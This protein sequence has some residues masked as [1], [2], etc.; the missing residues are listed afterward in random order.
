[1]AELK[2]TRITD[3]PV[4]T[5]VLTAV[6]ALGI[7]VAFQLAFDGQVSVLESGAFAVVFAAVLVGLS[8]VRQR[9]A[10]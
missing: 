8:L 2:D 7:Y 3:R 5:F 6:V 9:L 10:E 4:A 1:M